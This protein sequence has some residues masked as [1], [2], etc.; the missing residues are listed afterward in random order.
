MSYFNYCQGLTMT[1]GRFHRLFGGPPRK[2]ESPLEQRHMDLA[3]SIQAV[4]EEV[5][6]PA[7]PSRP[8]QQTGMKTSG[9]GRRR[10]AQL[11]R[12]RPAAARGRLR[13]PLDPAGGRRRRRRSGRRCSSGISFWTIPAGP[14]ESTPSK[15]ASSARATPPTRSRRFSATQ[16]V[17]DQRFADEAD[18]FDHVAGL[19]AAGKVVGWFQGRMEFGPRALGARSIL[20]DPRSP[21]MQATMNVKIKFR[22]SF[23]PF[24]PAVLQERATEWFDLKPEH[25]SP[26]MLLVAPCSS[27]A[28]FPSDAD[29]QQSDG[30]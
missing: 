12:Q 29:A 10:G 28:G 7:R 17:S 1:N 2:P 26:Y 24:A 16:G 9:A 8:S 19:L 4:T 15:E 20:G 18:L 30:T 11:R 22:E 21:A 23:R 25:E 13:G 14:K 5:D 6:A 3:A 27:I